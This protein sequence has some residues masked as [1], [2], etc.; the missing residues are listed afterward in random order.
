MPNFEAAL[1]ALLD[2]KEHLNDT[3]ILSDCEAKYRRNLI[4][5]CIEIAREYK[6]EIQQRD[7]EAGR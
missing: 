7:V 5:V 2:C 3:S 6:C 1:T 4:R